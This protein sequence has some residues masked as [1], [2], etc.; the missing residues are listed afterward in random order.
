MLKPTSSSSSAS[1][2]SPAP[3]KAAMPPMPT[4]AQAKVIRSSFLLLLF[5]FFGLI[6]V[7]CLSLL[8]PLVLLRLLLCRHYQFFIKFGCA[9]LNITVL[10][11]HLSPPSNCWATV[12]LSR[13]CYVCV[14]SLFSS[15]FLLPQFSSSSPLL[16]TAPLFLHPSSSVHMPSFRSVLPQVYDSFLMTR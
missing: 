14:L 5:V 9:F 16:S 11:T 7:F 13:L 4:L 8:L 3:P 1:S 2:S 6:L 15:F 12:C 10:V